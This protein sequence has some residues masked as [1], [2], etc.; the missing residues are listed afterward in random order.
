MKRLMSLTPL[1]LFAMLTPTSARASTIIDTSFCPSNAT[2]P[3]GV[4]N[5]ELSISADTLTSDANDYFFNVTFS[6]NASAPAFLNEFSFAVDG[7]QTPSGYAAVPTILSAPA[8]VTWTPFFDNVSASPS[9]CTSNTGSSQEVCTQSSGFGASLPGQT[10]TFSY[11][12]DLSGS[13]LIVPTTGVN[14]RA[15]F[16]NADGSNAGILSPDGHGAPGGGG[17]GSPVPEPASM[18]LLG[19]G[20]LGLGT[21][22]RRRLKK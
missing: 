16:L 18:L 14:L 1:L 19:S 22:L 12:V 10:L 21:K 9:S 7:V 11:H 15:Q 17:G 4:T 20:L 13:F 3:S 5:A 2:C 6:G 8:G